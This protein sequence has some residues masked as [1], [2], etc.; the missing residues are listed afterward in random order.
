MNCIFCKIIKG[1]LKSFKVWEDKDFILLI[2]PK[3]IKPGHLILIPK[4]HTD[5]IFSLPNNSYVKIFQTAKKIVKILSEQ[6]IWEQM[7]I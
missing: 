7:I 4:K 1:Q 5:Y 6:K 2:V 3:P